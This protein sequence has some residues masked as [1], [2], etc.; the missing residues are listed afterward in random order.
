MWKTFYVCFDLFQPTHCEKIKTN[1]ETITALLAQSDAVECN[2]T[3]D[4]N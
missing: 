1:D 2:G 3:A 4:V